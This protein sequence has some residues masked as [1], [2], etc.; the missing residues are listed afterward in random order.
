MA[1]YSD[2]NHAF[3]VG[4][5]VG[6]VQPQREDIHLTPARVAGVVSELLRARSE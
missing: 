3:I 6:D 1:Q 2:C 4:E 5:R